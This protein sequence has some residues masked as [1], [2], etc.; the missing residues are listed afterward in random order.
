MIEVLKNVTANAKQRKRLLYFVPE[1]PMLSQT[2]IEREINEL[3]KLNNLQITVFSLKQASGS[4]SE[5]V[6]KHTV[7][8]ALKVTELL[9]VFIF[10]LLHFKRIF[11]QLIWILRKG[12]NPARDIWLLIKSMGYATIFSTYKPDHIHVNFMSDV[13]TLIKMSAEI[14]N[15]PYSISGHAKDV[16]VEGHLI[17]EKIS[18]AKFVTI[19]NSNTYNEVVKMVSNTGISTNNIFNL[20]HGVPDF[21]ASVEK[22]NELK[23]SNVPI[24]V[25]IGRFV[26]KKGFIYLFSA[27]QKLKSKGLK[28]KLIIAGFGPLYKSMVAEIKSK[29]LVNIVTVLG[30]DKHGVPNN[31]IRTLLAAADIFVAAYIQTDD[32]DVDGVANVI[33]EAA[34]ANVPAVV[35]NSGS[36]N[37]LHDN[38]SAIIVGQ[39]DAEALSNGIEKLLHN[40]TLA[41]ELSTNAYKNAKERFNL[42]TNVKKLENLIEN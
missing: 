35:T 15:I 37:D 34:L 12:S 29:D 6:L 28:F 19:C 27:V 8:R 7:F 2:F 20:F 32:G 26:E 24:I 9:T 30:D 3:I 42:K 18:T 33:V 14:L 31:D 21:E 5:I 22:L 1:F 41:K 11:T 16:F 36:I 17:P 4:T 40:K 23:S 39:C 38:S 10:A 25:S 13:S